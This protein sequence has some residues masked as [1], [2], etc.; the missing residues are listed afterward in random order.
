MHIAHPPQTR[1]NDTPAEEK[2]PYIYQSGFGNYHSSEALPDALPLRGNVPLKSR[3]N[4]YPEHLN[5]TTFVSPRELAFH[6]WMYR[7]KP[8]A[9]HEPFSPLSCEDG[10]DCINNDPPKLEAC[11]LPTNP[12]V[13]FTPQ[14]Y[15]WGSLAPSLDSISD[16]SLT[17][18]QGLRTLAGNGDAT[19]SEGLAIHQYAFNTSM[20]NQAFVNHD[21]EFLI[22]PQTGALDIKSELGMLRI[23][24]GFIAVLPPGLRYSINLLGPGTVAKGYVLELFGGAHFTLPALGPLGANGLARPNDFQYPVASFDPPDHSSPSWEIVVKLSGKLYAYAQPHSP[25][26]VVAWHGRYAPYRYDLSLFSHLATHTD[27]LDPTAFT[28][29]V[30][31]SLRPGVNLVDFCIFGGGEKWLVARDTVRGLPYYH[32]TV[33]T[34]VCGVV[35]GVY[36]G[37]S[38]PLTEGGLSFEGGWMPHGEG[39]EV[40]R[41]GAEEKEEDNRVPRLLG[42]GYLGE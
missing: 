1:L 15:T 4:L 34:E 21:G 41:R 22:I 37:S 14:P 6:L 31:P 7:G 39:L 23:R 12:N 18:I 36:K 38:R 8:S 30:A 33:A 42:G 2:E 25:F 3:Y 28:V 27:Q 5:G 16:E 9:A 26:D 32:R 24:P 29:L 20:P 17:F 11:F 40:W 13:K 10:D 19:L 35:K